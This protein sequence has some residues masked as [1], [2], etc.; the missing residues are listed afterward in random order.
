MARITIPGT[1][2]AIV[3]PLVLRACMLIVDPLGPPS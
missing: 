3:R 2:Q 1:D